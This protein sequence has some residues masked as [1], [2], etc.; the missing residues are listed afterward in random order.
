MSMTGFLALVDIFGEDAVCQ[1][2]GQV[3]IEGCGAGDAPFWGFS[4]GLSGG[5]Y[6][7]TGVWDHM[8]FGAIGI[9]A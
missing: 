2:A 4:R 1:G 9:T 5:A 3:A 7:I 6:E 8:E